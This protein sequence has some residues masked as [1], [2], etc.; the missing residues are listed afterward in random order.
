MNPAKS[1]EGDLVAT[2]D[3]MIFDVKG[4]VHPPT[5]IVAFIRYFPDEKGERR[6]GGIAYEKVYSLSKRYSLLKDR[7]PQYLVYDSV[8]DEMLCEVPVENTRRLY[9]PTAKLQQL[10]GCK[11]L[12]ALESKALKSAT[13]LKAKAGV[14]WEAI[15]ISGSIL[16]GLHGALSDIDLIVY[17]SESCW[18]AHSA[19]ESLLKD[20][21][22]SFRP[23][24]IEDLRELFDFR[25][26]DTI[27][28]FEDFVRTES[29]KAWQGKFMETDYFVRFVK[30]WGEIDECYGDV[31][32]KNAGYSKIRAVI[33]DDSESIFTPCIYKIGNVQ[34][35]EGEEFEPIKEIAS[36]RGRFCE[37]AKNG[38]TLIVQG[39]VEQVTD[40]R[41]DRRFFRILVGNRPS[42]FMILE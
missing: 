8:F 17:G 41:Q 14:P 21:C 20:R 37:Q 39:K 34:I 12:D 25:S 31:Q 26:K 40:N 23:Y 10:R 32:Y 15:G 36:F 30:D 2:S 4:L 35:I 3:D 28:S 42:D 16:V 7:F 19:L 24:N 38:E 29:R 33:V 22:S 1:R 6:K 9:E 5:S 18:K 27:V 13:L 11:N